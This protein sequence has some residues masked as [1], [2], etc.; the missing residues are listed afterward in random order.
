MVDLVPDR[1]KEEYHTLLCHLWVI[2]KI[3]NSKRK[4]N[5]EKYKEFCVLTY[6]HILANFNNTD[7]RW[8]NI[9]PTLHSILAHS[10]EL[11]QNN[12][13]KGLGV[14]SEGGLENCDKF[15]RFYRRNLSRKINQE[16]N[17]EDCH[18]RLW[19]RS[20]PL[21]RNSGPPKPTCSR[22]S[23][24]HFTVSCPQKNSQLLPLSTSQDDIYFDQ[25]F[26]D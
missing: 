16:T 18:T 11:I 7:S 20:D 13:D 3:Y 8:I 21:I 4:V 2:I 17:M 12:D 10:W 19:L 1:F 23:L 6:N 15:L 22:C 26:L 5:I 25:L 9:S 14:F 24:D